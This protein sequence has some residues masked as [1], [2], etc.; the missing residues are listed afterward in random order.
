MEGPI[1]RLYG[2]SWVINAFLARQ[3]FKVHIHSAGLWVIELS[4]DN[5]I[6]IIILAVTSMFN[7]EEVIRIHSEQEERTK[8]RQAATARP[9][10]CS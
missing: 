9:E 7:V 4:T 8:Q 3:G 6:I 2:G 5:P 1:E 10:L